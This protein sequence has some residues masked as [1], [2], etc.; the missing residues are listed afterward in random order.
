MIFVS[1]HSVKGS[2]C[3]SRGTGGGG[4]K[5][6]RQREQKASL[7]VATQVKRK[8]F[9]VETMPQEGNGGTAWPIRD[10]ISLA[11]SPAG[12]SG[13]AS[14]QFRWA[15]SLVC[16]FANVRF[17][18]CVISRIC[19]FARRFRECAILPVCNFAYVPCRWQ[20]FIYLFIL[21]KFRLYITR[22]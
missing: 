14:V 9:D 6:T 10:A 21:Y 1:C 12:G 8:I 15:I 22:S 18:H 5:Y 19:N 11:V 4:R 7:P 3:C 20:I 13:L 2:G 17:C 16:S